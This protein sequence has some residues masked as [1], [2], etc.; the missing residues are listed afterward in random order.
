MAEGI[1]KW[2]S[3]EKGFGFIEPDGGGPEMFVHY[4]AITSPGYRSLEE[5]QK[6]GF[7]LTQGAEGPRAR[8]ST[9]CDRISPATAAP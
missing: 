3:A 7:E 5:R 1:V 9:L 8:A 2:F 4:S 6:V